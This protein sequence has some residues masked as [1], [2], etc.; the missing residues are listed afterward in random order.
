MRCIS[1]IRSR[2][3]RSGSTARVRREASDF[4]RHPSLGAARNA[5]GVKAP[6]LPP[7]TRPQ[8]PNP[9]RLAQALDADGLIFLLERG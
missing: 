3:A 7:S 1:S 4:I 5:G 2:S 6:R 9:S 8:A